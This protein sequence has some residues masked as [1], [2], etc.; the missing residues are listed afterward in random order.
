MDNNQKFGRWDWVKYKFTTSKTDPRKESQKVIPESILPAGKMKSSER[1][2]FINPLIRENLDEANKKGE[3][4]ALIRPDEIL[5]S[6]KQKTDQELSDETQKHAELANQLSLFDKNAKPL[7]PCPFLFTIKWHANNAVHNHVCDDWETSTAFFRR[8]SVEGEA[9]ALLS[10]KETY[11]EEYI[12]KGLCLAF[13]THSRRNQ[14]W[15]LVGLIRLDA[16]HQD[17]LFL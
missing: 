9:A 6:W 12:K 16:N 8:K 3:S 7:I 2:K 5:F 4:L 17:D 10:L 15:L 1:V 14:Q 11:E 13:S